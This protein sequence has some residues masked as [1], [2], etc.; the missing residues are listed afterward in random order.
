MVNEDGT[1]MRVRDTKHGKSLG[2]DENTVYVFGSE[3]RRI[4]INNILF[5]DY[6]EIEDQEQLLKEEDKFFDNWKT[7]ANNE[8][9]KN[10]NTLNAS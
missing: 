10:V 2:N 4:L 6:F 5:T 7:F 3:N 1:W 8:D 9:I